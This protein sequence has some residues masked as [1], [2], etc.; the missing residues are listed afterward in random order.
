MRPVKIIPISTEEYPTKAKRPKNSYMS[1]EKIKNN[2]GIECRDW[3]TALEEY[4]K[5]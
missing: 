2:L 3:K 5:N 1:K 4:L